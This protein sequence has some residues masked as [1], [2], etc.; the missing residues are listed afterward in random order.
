L[1]GALVLAA[2]MNLMNILGIGTW[3]QNLV[4]GFVVILAVAAADF[5]R[6]RTAR[7]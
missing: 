1:L 5:G 4:L 3:Y 2:V 7:T 6:R